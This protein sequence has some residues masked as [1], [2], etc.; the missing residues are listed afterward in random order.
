MGKFSKVFLKESQVV[1][2]LK[3]V[4]EYGDHK[5]KSTVHHDKEY[6]EFRVKF[7]RDGVHQKD[8]DYHTDEIGR[9]HV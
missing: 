2:S 3:K 7:H 9:A 1:E 6:D 8:A 5:L 4:G